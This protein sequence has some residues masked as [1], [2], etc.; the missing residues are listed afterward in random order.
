[1]ILLST[2][3]AEGHQHRNN[4]MAYAFKC[5]ADDDRRYLKSFQLFL[6]RSSEHQCMLDF[7]HGVLPDILGS[8]G[9][10]RSSLNILGVGSGAGEI[11]LE[12]LSQ[13]YLKYPGLKVDNEVVDP[14][15]EMLHNYKVLVSK[16]PNLEHV[17]FK[18]NRMTASEFE[19]HWREKN[20]TK[21]MD[22]IHMVQ[23]LYYVADP[24]ATVSFFRSLLN[25]NGKLMIILVSDKSGWGR[26]WKTYKT[27]LCQNDISQCLTTG[28]IKS[29][30]N[31]D[32]IKYKSYQLPSQMD[33]TECFTEGD[34]RGE[35]LLDFLTEVSDFSKSAPP[36]L[37]TGVLDLLRHSDCS[38]EVDG[39]I[40]FNNALEV[41]V[42]DA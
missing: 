1:M 2:F 15:S 36:D 10:G 11:D 33:I 16:T 28:D 25:K 7:I 31:A 3:G 34:E 12:M 39:K 27:D 22:F 4:T 26:L 23:M 32:G 21:K 30:L 42:L 8:V 14:S 13:L 37:K 38:A 20:L 19:N 6:E 9:G 29:F 5:L 18:W 24:I 17:N 35:L 40:V 41:L